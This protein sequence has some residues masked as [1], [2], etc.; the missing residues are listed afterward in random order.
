MTLIRDKLWIK[1]FA[2][3]VFFSVGCFIQDALADLEAAKAAYHSGDYA[4]AL[5]EFTRLA[6]KV[7]ERLNTA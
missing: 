3:L 1:A 2:C 6:Q 5:Q 7:I 4:M